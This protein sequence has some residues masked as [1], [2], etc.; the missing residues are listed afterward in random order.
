MIRTTAKSAILYPVIVFEPITSYSF[1]STEIVKLYLHFRGLRIP[2]ETSAL[3][4]QM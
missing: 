4:I 2:V 1:T 3:R